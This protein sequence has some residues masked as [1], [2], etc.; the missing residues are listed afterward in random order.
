MTAEDKIVK[1]S[2]LAPLWA[3]DAWSDEPSRRGWASMRLPF[4][5]RVVRV[6]YRRMPDGMRYEGCMGVSAHWTAKAARSL[7]A[8]LAHTA[9]AHARAEEGSHGH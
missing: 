5:W 3:P 8:A 7:A 6:H 4:R 9:P 2:V 1:F